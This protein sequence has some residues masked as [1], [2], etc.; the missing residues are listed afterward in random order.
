M[1]LHLDEK[2]PPSARPELVLAAAM[3]GVILISLDVSVVNVAI[4]A[5]QRSLHAGID[6]LQWIVSLYTLTYAVFLLSAGALSDRSGPRAVFLA[7]LALFTIAS[8]ACGIAPSLAV[9]LLGRAA[10]GMGAALLVPSSMAIL[11]LAFPDTARRARAVGLWA[12]AGSL[13][14]AAGPLLGGA[15]IDTVGWR[16]I[17]LINV[18]I[19]LAGGWLARRNAPQVR[20]GAARMLDLPGQG[21]A[22]LMLISLVF[23]LIEAGAARLDLAETMF[24]LLLSGTMLI[25]LL[26][27][28]AKAAEPMM[29][30]AMFGSRIFCVTTAVGMVLNFVFYGLI[31][32]FSLFFQTVQH[33]SAFATGLAFLPMTALIMLVNILAGRLIGRFGV[34][35]VL[36]VG[37]LVAAIGYGAML[38][39]DAGTSY[40]LII[41]AFASAGVGIALTV[42]AV[43]NAALDHAYAG[44]TGIASGVL[45]ASRQVGGAIGVAAF[46]AIVG[47]AGPSGFVAAMHLSIGMASA[48]LVA[49]LLAT[50]LLIPARPG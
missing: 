38:G 29:P 1:T 6:D 14:L 3:T 50:L 40:A 7:G 17:F 25:A 10:Q 41:P 9:L 28:E 26:R 32:V 30:L 44:R 15:L 20:A 18:P 21:L 48:T 46:G 31:F 12:G 2:Q 49:A 23:T 27:V 24:G 37:L 33:R 11:Q 34:R 16:T 4:H 47:A 5:L 36:V 8:L 35:P 19:G 43:V 42:P 22:A 39:I 45:N 13:A